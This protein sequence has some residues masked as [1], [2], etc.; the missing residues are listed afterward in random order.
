MHL[1]PDAHSAER[2]MNVYKQNLDSELGIR[3]THLYKYQKPAGTFQ[4][5]QPA[6]KARHAVNRSALS[7]HQSIVNLPPLQD[8]KSELSVKP[9]FHIRKVEPPA[10]TSEIVYAREN[11]KSPMKRSKQRSDHLMV[12]SNFGRKPEYLVRYDKQKLLERQREEYINYIMDSIP[13][14]KRIV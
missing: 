5:L 8:R 2:V 1:S 14:G 3:N 11:I 6:Q 10:L 13:V 7:K 4:T 12:N 9:D